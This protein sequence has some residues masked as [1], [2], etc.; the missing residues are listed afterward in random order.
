MVLSEG[1]R[2]PPVNERALIRRTDV[3]HMVD[4]LQGEAEAR[5]AWSHR[6][7]HSQVR[8]ALTCLRHGMSGESLL[9]TRGGDTWSACARVPM[10][11][12]SSST[13]ALVSAVRGTSP[14]SSR[15]FSSL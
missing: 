2:H 12:A 4:S 7:P 1:K 15:L 11:L 6:K 5:I 3:E 9:H 13:H 10:M 14:R 8:S